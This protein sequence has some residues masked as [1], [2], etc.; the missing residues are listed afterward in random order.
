[1]DNTVPVRDMV[2]SATE[3]YWDFQ[4]GQKCHQEKDL[5]VHCLLQGIEMVSNKIVNFYELQEITQQ[6]DENPAIFLNQLQDTMIQYTCL[7][8]ASPVG[9]TVLTTHF[10][11]QSSPDFRK[12]KLERLR[13]V[14]K[15]PYRNW[16]K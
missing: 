16:L 5:M 1:M 6:S 2:V 11:S 12:K 7:D 13:R 3:P 4:Q 9:A 15:F 8:P 10:I 14:S